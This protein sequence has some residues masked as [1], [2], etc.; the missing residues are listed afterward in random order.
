MLD[1]NLNWYRVFL[2]VANSKSLTDASNK[3]NISVPAI[4][5]TIK[6]LENYLGTLLFYRTNDGMRLTVAGKDFYSHIDDGFT[7]IDLGEK[8]LLQKNDFNNGEI[9]IG[10]PS[11]VANFF[12][13]DYIEK[14]YKDYPNLKIKI[15]GI[16]DVKGFLGLLENHKVDFVIDNTKTG[17]LANKDLI[18]KEI[19]EI[20]N[21][22]ISKNQIE[23]KDIKKLEEFTYLLPFEYTSTTKRLEECFKQN[24]IFIKHRKEFDMTE[25]RI[26]ATKKNMG[27]GYVMENTVKDELEKGELYNIKVP[28]ELPTSTISLYYLKGQLTKVSKEFINNYLNK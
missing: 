1:I 16:A 27:I 15:T 11:H 10:C 8:L 26:T 9:V 5:R 24:N 17:N 14:V 22:L 6:Q 20:K 2:V 25:M 12:L 13:M 23:I 18:K 21:V 28:F 7:D 4:S 3:L 19:K